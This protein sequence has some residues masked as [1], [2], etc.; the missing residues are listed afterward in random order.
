MKKRS[1]LTGKRHFKRI[2]IKLENQ[3][4]NTI[5]KKSKQRDCF[6]NEGWNDTKVI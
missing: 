4:K 2:F 3:Q 5:R 1:D 6:D